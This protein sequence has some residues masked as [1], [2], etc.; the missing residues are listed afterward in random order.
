MILR[1]INF[2]PALD[3]AGV[4]GFFGEGYFHHRFFRPF[5]LNFK[6]CTF[7][8]KT[9]TLQARQGNMP[10]KKNGITPKE[11]KP[12]CIKVYFLKGMML[13][14]VGL[15]GPGAEALF[16]SGR[17][18]K[19]TTPFFISFMST[20]SMPEARISELKRFVL[21]FKKYLP[22]FSAKVGLQI[23]YSC[24]NAGLNPDELVYEA[25]EGLE[26]AGR[27][28][29]PLM[30]KF[31]ILAPIKAILEISEN[32]NCDAICVSN[33]IPFGHLPEKIKWQRLFGSED[34]PLAKFGGGGLSGRPL[35]IP[36]AEWVDSAIKAGVKKP[37]NA[38]GGILHPYDVDT[39]FNAGAS[40]V[41]I[42]SMAT[43]RP[44]RVKKTIARAYY[45]FTN[46][47]PM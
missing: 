8:A 16:N 9:T 15:S 21:M 38:G 45:L 29:I 10:M 30:P 44:W 7:V 11:T 26:I 2:G 36:V 20:H 17:W 1:G 34:S 22:R 43:L 18:Q 4:E 33:A 39:L 23:N 28:N 31:N 13:N 24:P 46:G 12:A 41:F 27:L 19:R 40:S 42:G 37:I 3:A 25:A 35:L 32:Q 6:G 47:G 14:A 5:G